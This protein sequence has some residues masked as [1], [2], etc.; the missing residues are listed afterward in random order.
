MWKNVGAIND[1]FF[2]A[3]LLAFNPAAA[4]YAAAF[5]AGA[6]E[7][8][9]L[10]VYSTCTGLPPQVEV[11]RNLLLG[12]RTAREEAAPLPATMLE[13]AVML[14]AVLNLALYCARC[15]KWGDR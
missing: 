7:Y 6:A 10:P 5:A 14:T 4:A 11:M 9:R 13:A 8:W 3:F 1:D 12:T 15:T 2:G